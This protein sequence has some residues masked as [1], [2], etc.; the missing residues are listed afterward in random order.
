M[1][2]TVLLIEDEEELREV[3]RDAL[4][5]EGYRVVAAREGQEALEAIPRID[6]ICLVLLDLLMPGMNGWDFLDAVKARPDFA[7]VPVV[8]HT[9]APSR[10]PSGVAKVLQ[11]PLR[12]E[13]LLS[14][15]REYCTQ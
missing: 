2:H 14:V 10:A 6:H 12:I 3:M 7:K 8:V 15:V 13:R 1:I 4:E 11:K 9:S 5:D